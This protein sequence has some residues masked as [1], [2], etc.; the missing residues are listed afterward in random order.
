M[1]LCA[2]SSGAAGGD[3]AGPCVGAQGCGGGAERQP[4]PRHGGRTVAD[5]GV[6]QWWSVVLWAEA[7]G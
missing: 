5:R 7:R 4:P 6:L 1:G 3:A 2:G